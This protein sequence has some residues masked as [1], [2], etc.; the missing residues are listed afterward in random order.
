MSN[1]DFV[2]MHRYQAI[3]Q[4]VYKKVKEWKPTTIVELG[5][6][7]GALTVATSIALKEM[8]SKGKIHSYDIIGESSYELSGVKS[9]SR[10]N[11]KKRGLEKYVN[12]IEGDVFDTWVKNPTNFNLLLID[13]DNTWDKLYKILI[14]NKFINN[15]IKKGGKILIE[16]GDPSHPRI[17]PITLDLFNSKFNS[18]I[19]KLSYLIGSGRT[20]ISILEI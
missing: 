11:I 15:Q 5:H 14:D 6:G 1:I 7:S 2:N 8:N 18:P 16:G 13:I 3:E 10:E 17:T 9:D 20:S 12:F 4:I 19:F